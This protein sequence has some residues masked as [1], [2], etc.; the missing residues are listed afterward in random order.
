MS[1]NTVCTTCGGYIHGKHLFGLMCHCEDE[2]IS[3]K[4]HEYNEYR[5]A[6]KENA[7]LRQ[8]LEIQTINVNTYMSALEDA[9]K[10]SAEL[11]TA[12]EAS[13][14]V[15]E[16]QKAM[17]ETFT[18]DNVRL[19]KELQHYKALAEERRV[20]LVKYCKVIMNSYGSWFC[21]CCGKINEHAENCDWVRLTKED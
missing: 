8:Q 12:F 11:R 16:V 10:L 3:L 4:Q 5:R 2:Y 17:C 1:D 20:A 7:E 15:S 9:E 18:V 6:I 14:T 13:R 21:K 19:F